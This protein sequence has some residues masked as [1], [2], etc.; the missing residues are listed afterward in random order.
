MS[1]MIRSIGWV[2]AL[3]SVLNLAAWCGIGYL[4][5][6]IVKALRTYIRVNSTKPSDPVRRT[7][8]E[9]I[10][11]HRTRC[12][13]SQELLAEKLGV[14][15]QAVS[16][17]ETGTAEPSTSNLLAMAKAFNISPEELLRDLQ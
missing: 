8:G 16:K 5:W 9:R 1:N 11:E 3:F 2:P 17:W 12:G 14:S 10:K 7:L 13:M 6:L 4:V 15:R